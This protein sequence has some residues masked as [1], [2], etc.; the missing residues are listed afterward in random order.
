MTYA[1]FML[2]FDGFLESKGIKKN[3]EKMMSRND[4]LDL[5]DRFDGDS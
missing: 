4:L 1:E 5:A 2:S 3:R